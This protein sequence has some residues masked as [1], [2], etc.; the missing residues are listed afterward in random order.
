MSS[1]PTDTFTDADLTVFFPEIWAERINDFFRARLQAGAFFLDVSED[2]SGG[3][4][5]LNIPNLTEM[6]A[7]A[8]SN[9]TAVTLNI[10]GAFVL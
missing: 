9:A 2:F 1:Y 5:T 10:L 3:G 6:T 4:D 7:N 8:K